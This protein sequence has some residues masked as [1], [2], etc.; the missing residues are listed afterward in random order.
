M[1]RAVTRRELMASAGAA[2]LAVGYDPISR[3]W[4]GHAL[5]AGRFAHAPRLDGTLLLDASSRR[6]ASRDQGNIVTMSPAAILRPGSVSDIRKMILFCRAHGIGVAARG[7]GH[8]TFGQALTSGLVIEMRALRRIHSIGPDNAVVDAGVLWR[9]L[10]DAAYN[11]GLTPPA[12]TGYTK[13]SIGGTLSVGGVGAI[14]TNDAGAQIDRVR[15]LEVVTGAGEVV[16]CSPTR[17]PDLFDAA[18]GGL[19]QCCVI[20]RATVDLVP[21]P[22]MARTWIINYANTRQFMGDMRTLLARGQLDVVYNIQFPF[23]TS[24]LYQLQAVKFSDTLRLPSTTQL[25][26]GLSVPPL[27]AIPRDLPYLAYTKFVDLTYDAYRAALGF[28]DL[29]KP[30]FDAWL[31]DRTI[32]A[33][34]ADV[35]PTLTPTDIGPTGFLLLLP[36]RRSS[37]RRPYFRLPDAPGSEFVYLF[38]ILTSNVLPGRDEAFASRMLERNR[39]LHDKARAAGGTRYPIGAIEFSREDWAQHYGS[40]WKA[41]SKLKRTYD[42]DNIL[43]AGVGIFV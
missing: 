10:I 37:M 9:E 33:Y 42:P 13:L 7:Q 17:R 2:A 14:S 23:G 19:G 21:A 18:L 35:V 24:L 15:E 34:L 31:P 26:R 36:Q 1:S 43:A 30:W 28:D 38:D 40:Q 20:T 8:T 32:T 4:V 16:T 6:A 25:L 3:R 29:V 39:R 22:R 5:A 11:R 41:F 12:I 27:L